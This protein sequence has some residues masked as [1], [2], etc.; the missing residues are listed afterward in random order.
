[1]NVAGH[2]RQT[3]TGPQ[4]ERNTAV[5]VARA[6]QDFMKVRSALGFIV[7]GAGRRFRRLLTLLDPSERLLDVELVELEQRQEVEAGA[8]EIVVAPDEDAGLVWV[9]ARVGDGDF[10]DA[11]AIDHIVAVVFHR[12]ANEDEQ[13]DLN[14]GDEAGFQWRSGC[15][16]HGS[17]KNCKRP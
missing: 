12:L 17:P 16:M 13:Y 9:L 11:V 1:M 6:L 5:V 3:A 7:G 10:A 8:A 4:V 14:V 2:F 15:A